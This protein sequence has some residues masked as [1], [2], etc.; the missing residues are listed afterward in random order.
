MKLNT[1]SLY[2]ISIK[3]PEEWKVYFNPHSDISKESGLIKIDE[4]I[5][6]GHPLSLSIRWQQCLS[7]VDIN[8]YSQQ[9][10]NVI[11]K[12]FKNSFEMLDSKLIESNGH[13]GV[14]FNYSYRANH[15]IFAFF[16]KKEVVEQLQA[17]VYCNISRRMVI[18]NI[19]STPE[20]FINKRDLLY[21]IINSMTCHENTEK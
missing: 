10:S 3:H 5:S 12:K 17:A 2:G 9:V 1:F 20:N 14:L 13:K 6:S 11:S 8:E 18:V 4:I 19:A 7:D 15:Q 21:Q 16:G